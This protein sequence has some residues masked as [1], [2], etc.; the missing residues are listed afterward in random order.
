MSPTGRDAL[1][2]QLVLRRAI[3]SQQDTGPIEALVP[4]RRNA[5]GRSRGETPAGT[6]EPASNAEP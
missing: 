5:L 1:H 6:C 2:S 4:G 3:A